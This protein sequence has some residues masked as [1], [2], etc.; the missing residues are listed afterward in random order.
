L[1]T[2]VTL[3]FNA[4]FIGGKDACAR[5]KPPALELYGVRGFVGVFFTNLSISNDNKK[6]MK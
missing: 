2:A 3:E 5:L 4:R 6:K 1:I